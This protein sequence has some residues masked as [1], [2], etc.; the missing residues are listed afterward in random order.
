M[1]LAS[2]SVAAGKRGEG[3]DGKGDRDPQCGNCED[4]G[5][6]FRGDG[7][8]NFQA[9]SVVH[10]ITI[11]RLVS[12]RWIRRWIVV[13]YLRVPSQSSHLVLL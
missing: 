10:T 3:Y 6:A 8:F 1:P 11:G 12:L 13:P 5:P 7:T 2:N 4:L 9:L